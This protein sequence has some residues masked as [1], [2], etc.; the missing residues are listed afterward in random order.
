LKDFA[1]RALASVID[2]AA[3]TIKPEDTEAV[4]SELLKQIS[5]VERRSTRDSISKPCESALA[6]LAAKDPGLSAR[7]A[8]YDQATSQALTWRELFALQSV[9]NVTESFP[10]AGRLIDT[11]SPVESSIRPYFAVKPTIST[12]AP[13]IFGEQANWMA[14]EASVRLIGKPVGELNMIRLS[15]TSRT[16]AVPHDGRHYANVAVPLPSDPQVADLKT[17]LL[18]DATH[19]PLSFKAADA[20]SSA[21]LQDYVAMGGVIQTV[22][23]EAGITRFIG[24]PDA[25][26]TLIPLGNLPKFQSDQSLVQQTCWRFD[27]APMWAQNRYFFVL[28]PK[29]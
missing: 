18:V 1:I 15:P 8:A 13:G 6:K 7:I 22:H 26:Y 9:K 28:L 11:Q 20:V 21:E 16:A 17:A 12:V 3:T 14:H 29:Q 25:A 27:L 19:G 10:A 24:L 23:L 4:Y 2:A 5:I